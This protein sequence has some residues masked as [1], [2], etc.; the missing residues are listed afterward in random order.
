MVSVIV[1]RRH[2]HSPVVRR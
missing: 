2:G 1:V